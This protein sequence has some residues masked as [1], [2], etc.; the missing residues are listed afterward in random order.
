MKQIEILDCTLRDG[1]RII[2]CKY[3]DETIIGLGKYLKRAG[4]DIIELGFL[5]DSVVF[6]GNSTFFLQYLTQIHILKRYV[7]MNRYR[8]KSMLFLWTLDYM[9]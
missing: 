1:G 5:R 9:I 6:S 3:P 2:D 8:A 4:V 7:R